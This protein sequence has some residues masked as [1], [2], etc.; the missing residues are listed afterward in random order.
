MAREIRWHL[1]A[2]ASSLRGALAGIK[3]DFLKLSPAVTGFAAGAAAGLAA[4]TAAAGA[5]A[6]AV[7]K[8]TNTAGELSDL[9]AKSGIATD[10]LQKLGYAARLVGA[11]QGQVAQATVKLGKAISDQNP[12]LAQLGLSFGALRALKPEE[13]FAAVAAS[14]NRLGTDTEKSAAAMGVFGKSGAELLP[15]IKSDMAGAADEAERLGLVLDSETVAAGDA[16]GD[17]FDKV[18]LALGNVVTQF[19]AAIAT[20]GGF[21]QAVDDALE[22]L[23]DLGKWVAD[24]RDEIHGFFS[25]VRMSAEGAANAARSLAAY[26][27]GIPGVSAIS[28]WL[29]AQG[30]ITGSGVSG[31]ADAIGGDPTHYRGSGERAGEEW[32]KGFNERVKEYVVDGLDMF[33]SGGTVAERSMA[34][35]QAWARAAGEAAAAEMLGPQQ[36][37]ADSINRL[38]GEAFTNVAQIIPQ[39]FDWRDAVEGVGDAFSQLGQIASGVLGGIFSLAGRLISIFQSVGKGLG[40]ILSSAAAVGG[41]V[42]GVAGSGA[43]I[44]SAIGAAAGPLA[45]KAIG[46]VL[47]PGIG[48]AVGAVLGGLAGKL[49]GGLFGGGKKKDT[50]IP[51]TW[52]ETFAKAE[53]AVDQFGLQAA[54]GIKDLLG[55]PGDRRPEAQ[56]FVDKQLGR[57]TSAM[58]AIGGLEI[59]SQASAQAQATI[60]TTTFWATV[61]EQGLVKGVDALSAPFAALKDKLAAGGFDVNALLGGVGGLFDA[62]EGPA[63]AA[64]E[65]ADGLNQALEG[66]ALAGYLTQDSFTAFGTSAQDAFSQAVAGGLTNEQA[67]LAIAPLLGNIEEASRTYGFT[68]DENT[69]ALLDQA[70]AAGIAFPTDPME[71][72]AAAL[73][74]LVRLLGGDIPE[75]ANTAA[76]AIN[77]LGNVNPGGGGV[78][79]YHQPDYSAASGMY[80]PSLPRTSRPDGASVILAHPG[81]EVSIR[82][83]GSAGGGGMNVN[84]ALG[85]GSPDTMFTTLIDGLRRNRSAI[86]T[87]FRRALATQGA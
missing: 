32:A 41:A 45:L 15:L 23:A 76:H 58:S 4:V 53:K 39:T 63:R 2:E 54:R 35:I 22:V 75:A 49:F 27:K 65:A 37:S 28:D 69:Q 59:N 33:R 21:Q 68:I 85:G 29:K 46:S 34:E 44:G 84:I 51:P 48:T 42:G 24:H 16:L 18:E 62:V 40:S 19:G 25:L 64:L 67:L 12:A 72:A 47:A 1:V 86:V 14:I 56:A 30:Q 8:F 17:S 38:Y 82:P 50:V 74:K 9:S 57:A 70:H 31:R 61:A 10:S 6:A 77:G 83:G 87:E 71:R 20:T 66:I 79:T 5:A 7:L 80:V 11:D 52:E 81:E 60:F 13:Q 43:G 73:E 78:P 36:L 3:D 55:K 26:A